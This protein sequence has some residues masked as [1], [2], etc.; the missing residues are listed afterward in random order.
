MRFRASHKGG[1]EDLRLDGREAG[2]DVDREDPPEAAKVHDDRRRQLR[3][4]FEATD[5]VRAAAERNHRVAA[6]FRELEE[7]RD[8]NLVL[9]VDGQGRAAGDAPGPEAEQDPVPPSTGV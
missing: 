3:M 7:T 6:A 1:S 5:H 4:D 9:R 2:F 8:P